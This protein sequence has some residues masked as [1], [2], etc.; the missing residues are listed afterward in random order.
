MRGKLRRG[1]SAETA[2]RTTVVVCL[3]PALDHCLGF[4]K[5]E[6][7][8]TC[9]ALIAKSTVKAFHIPVLP[10]ATWLDVGCSWAAQKRSF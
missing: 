2:V 6:E 5:T 1:E 9:Q 8:F 7:Q 4:T 10:R 3:T